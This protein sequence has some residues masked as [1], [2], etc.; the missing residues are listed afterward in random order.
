MVEYNA[1]FFGL[2]QNLF[3]VLKEEL[4]EE[5][6]LELFTKIMEKG[7]KA[8]YDKTGFKKGNPGDFARVVGERDES[9][10]LRVEF[11]LIA[12]NKLIYEFWTDPFPGLNGAVDSSKLD[13]TYMSFKVRYLLG[14][15]WSYKTVKHLWNKADCTQHVIEKK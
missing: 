9:V 12:N 13:A 1:A 11:P 14:E 6:A 2:Y 8:A 3:L 10:G 5:K 7:L 4:G 15:D